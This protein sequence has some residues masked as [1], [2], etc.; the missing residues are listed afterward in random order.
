MCS[1]VRMARTYNG[2][3]ERNSK[4]VDVLTSGSELERNLNV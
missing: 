4:G 2:W 3:Y 1:L